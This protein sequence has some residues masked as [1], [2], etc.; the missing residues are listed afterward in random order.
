MIDI[1]YPKNGETLS[2]LSQEQLD[3]IAKPEVEAS[4]RINWSAL[5]VQGIDGTVPPPLIVDCSP[6]VN[7]K[8]TIRDADDSGISWEVPVDSGR[9]EVYDLMVGHSYDLTIETDNDRSE[10]IRFSVAGQPP[11]WIYI[12]GCNN[13]RD[14]GGWKTGG[15]HHVKQGMIYRTSE[16]D[17]HLTITPKG[18]KQ[19]LDLGM[20][21]EIDVRGLGDSA[22]ETM[23]GTGIR[24]NNI[25][26]AAYKDIF[27]REQKDRYV[28]TYRLLL[29]DSNYPLYIHC[30]GGIDRTGTWVYILNG[31]LGVCEDDLC[32]DYEISSFATWG[33]RSRNSEYF[34]EF[35]AALAEYDD[36]TQ[37]ACTGFMLDCGLDKGDIDLLRKKLLV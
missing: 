9:A 10:M 3:F 36:D 34:T 18:R 7:G 16:L 27:T 26:L 20:R 8:M 6:S 28:E 2:F 31:M 4:G 23:T 32:L 24:Y 14:I 17:T 13:C 30:W 22:S 19:L 12:D 21:C 35:R 37:K 33:N 25:K 5:R 1:V 15:G 11:R 29:D